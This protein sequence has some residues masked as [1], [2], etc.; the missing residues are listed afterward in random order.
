MT[1]RKFR[2]ILA[3]SASFSVPYQQDLL[4]SVH[5]SPYLLPQSDKQRRFRF[6]V[7]LLLSGILSAL[8]IVSAL[9]LQFLPKTTLT[10]D[11]NPS[12]ELTL[13]HYNRVIRVEGLDQEGDMLA[14]NLP[15]KTGSLTKVLTSIQ[16]TALQDRYL[17]SQETPMLFGIE[18]TSYEQELKIK[19]LLVDHFLESSTPILVLNQHTDDANH[20]IY[21]FARL[22]SSGLFTTAMPIFTTTA[23]MYT[24]AW[25][26]TLSPSSPSTSSSNDS[27]SDIADQ[28]YTLPEFTLMEFRSLADSLDITEAKLQLVLEI[29]Q[30]YSA[31][32]TVA[33][34]EQLAN[35]PLETLYSLYLALNPT[36]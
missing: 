2:Q 33:D 14:Q 20:W 36:E 34:L 21:G 26:T 17:E 24:S 13:N 5:Q 6:R 31:Y 27:T 11:I 25:Q 28:E 1:Y 19:S 9:F 7:L 3:D 16:N 4:D 10:I 23:M 22:E 29:Y 8:L 18:G 30:G 15:S 35:T 12:L 32:Q